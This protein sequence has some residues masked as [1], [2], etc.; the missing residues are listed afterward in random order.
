MFR[1]KFYKWFF[2]WLGKGMCQIWIGPVVLRE[3]VCQMRIDCC[4]VRKHVSDE[5][6][7][8]F[9]EKTCVKWELIVVLLGNMCQ[10]RIVPV[11]LRENVCQMRID[12]CLVR[13]HVSDENWLCF[14]DENV[15]QMRINSVFVR[16]TCVRWELTLLSWGK[17]VSDEN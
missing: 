9:C 10:I 11:V 3:K 15:C 16:K 4:L 14:L 17:H 8:L 5:N 7:L 2:W 13:K 6:W 12:C 1:Y